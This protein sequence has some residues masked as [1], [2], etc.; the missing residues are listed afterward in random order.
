MVIYKKRKSDPETIKELKYF[1]PERPPIPEKIIEMM[2]SM[3]ITPTTTNLDI[4]ANTKNTTETVK[5]GMET[6]TETET[7]TG[8]K[9]TAAPMNVDA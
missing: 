5:T 2:K 8:A 4:S 3:E 6:E 7:E 1:A 9:N